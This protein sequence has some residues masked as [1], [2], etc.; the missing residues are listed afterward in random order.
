MLS[1][2]VYDLA[3]EEVLIY[4]KLQEQELCQRFHGELTSEILE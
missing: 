4:Y 1:I 3:T 2:V